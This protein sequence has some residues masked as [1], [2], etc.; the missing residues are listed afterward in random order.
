MAEEDYRTAKK[1]FLV[2]FSHPKE[3]SLGNALKEAVIKGLKK[4]NTAAEIRIQDLYREQ[5]DPLLH[6]IEEND[7]DQVTIKMKENIVW[8]D[9]IV[10]VTPLWW[11]NIPAMLKGYFDRIFTEHFAF[12]Y[13]QAAMPVG[14]LKNK[15]AILI[16]TCDTPSLLARFSKTTLGFKSIIRGV[17]KLSG[18]KNSRLILFGSVLT[19]TEEKRKKWI[20]R[21]EAAGEAFAR[22][23]TPLT[24]VKRGIVTMIRAVR[25]PLFSFVF[26][27]VLL[28]SAIG[29][30][31]ARDFNWARFMIAIFLGLMCHAAVSFS[32]EVADE[33]ADEINVNRTMFNGGT[34]LL[35]EGL[36]TK[37]TLNWGWI[38]T[39]WLGLIIAAVLVLQFRYHWLLFLG[40]AVGLFLGLEY[41]FYPLRFSRI[42]LGEIAAFI[43]Y[44]VP[45]MLVGLVSQVE[46]PAV[47]QVASGFRFYLLSLPISLSVFVTLCLTQIPDTDADREAGK[48]S[49]S[50]LLQPKNVMILS[51]LV[52]LVC[53]IFC[54]GLVL[55]G[56]L[57]LKYSIA[58]SIFPLLTSGVIIKNLSAYEIPAGMKMINIM[59]M[60]VTTTVL[61]GIIPAVYFFNNPVQVTLLK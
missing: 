10:F 7:R 39:S 23:D 25:L 38:I 58:I 52:L 59:G 3:E 30:S 19:S 21:V 33:K 9:G 26:G 43:G 4:S 29:S 37:R 5:F 60:S 12:Q 41:S 6:D 2:V 45:M 57:P 55:L 54:F 48:R 28:G 40:I 46:N 14:L 31:I 1:N 32:N 42:G 13:N 61:C 17:L 35:S 15:K 50:V 20:A 22:P 24:K 34:G 16:G 53:A 18:I 49:I 56:I 51:A 44:G 36:I 8:A 47:N 11:A 27:S